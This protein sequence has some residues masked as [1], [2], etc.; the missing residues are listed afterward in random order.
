MRRQRRT[1]TPRAP[2]SLHSIALSSAE[3]A[4]ARVPPVLPY[5]QQRPSGD[6]QRDNVIP[7]RHAT[8]PRHPWRPPH[9]GSV[10]GPSTRASSTP[11]P[12]PPDRNPAFDETDAI[13]RKVSGRSRLG[14]PRGPETETNLRPKVNSRGE[15]GP[16]RKEGRAFELITREREAPATTARER[17]LLSPYS[18]PLW[19]LRP[20][21]PLTD[22]IPPR[23]L[24]RVGIPSPTQYR[25]WPYSHFPSRI[26]S[27][28]PRR[29][30]R[31]LR[32]H[33]PTC[34]TPRHLES[35]SFEFTCDARP[36]NIQN[37]SWVQTPR[38]ALPPSHFM[39]ECRVPHLYI[40]TRK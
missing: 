18:Y 4:I 16:T 32:I 11:P 7:E 28:I 14:P 35:L 8:P 30:A 20:R 21:A 19:Y 6:H 9:R 1:P 5:P 38:R 25:R 27:W 37:D 40:S 36:I 31:I 12:N 33:T 13:R 29:F 26:G 10:S 22:P 34:Q 2:Q 23:H 15:L 17:I 39:E 3:P 24:S